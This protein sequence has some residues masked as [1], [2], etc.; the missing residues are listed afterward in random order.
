MY[1]DF[2]NE[3][4]HLGTE[5]SLYTVKLKTDFENIKKKMNIFEV[6]INFLLYKM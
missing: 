1:T 2:A 5:Y 4:I 6:S 3:S